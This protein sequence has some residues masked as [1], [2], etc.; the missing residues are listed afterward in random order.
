VWDSIQKGEAAGLQELLAVLASERVQSL[1]SGRPLQRAAEPLALYADAA[2]VRSKATAFV[3]ALSG[4]VSG[5]PAPKEETPLKATM[6]VL[7]KALLRPDAPGNVD[8]ICDV[9]R[10][11]LT[12]DSCAKLAALVRAICDSPDVVVVRIKDRFANPS[13]GGWRDVMVNY[14]LASDEAKHVCELQLVHAS[15]LTA[16]KGLPGHAIYNIVRNATEFLE[17]LF[18][19]ITRDERGAGAGREGGRGRVRGRERRGR[20]GERD[21]IEARV[22]RNRR[23]VTRWVRQRPERDERGAGEERGDESSPPRHELRRAW[24]FVILVIF[25]KLE[26]FGK[27]SRSLG[28]V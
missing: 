16:R 25:A 20:R 9:V 21:R 5:V 22:E 17:R 3:L 19:G 24:S 13:G 8:R 14:Y 18:G 27:S 4:K 1:L 26:E 7:E 2:G 23:G 6:R 11:M 10:D 15:L 12:V 28:E